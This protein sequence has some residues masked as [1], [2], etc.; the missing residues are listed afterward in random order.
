[1]T[2][3]GGRIQRTSLFAFPAMI[4]V[5]IS[6]R[7]AGNL[8]NFD[9]FG[10]K[11]TALRPFLS[12]PLYVKNFT[13]KTVTEIRA[14]KSSSTQRQALKRTP[15]AGTG[16]ARLTSRWPFPLIHCGRFAA[17]MKTRPGLLIGSEELVATVANPAGKIWRL[18]Q[19]RYEPAD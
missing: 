5:T 12:I 6:S 7:T 1:M 17:C 13:T 15:Q 19:C 11:W 14:K 18:C 2:I 10:T 3:K 8:N 16:A 4:F 9:S